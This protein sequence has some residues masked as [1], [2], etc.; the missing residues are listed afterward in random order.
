MQEMQVLPMG[1]EDPLEGDMAAYSSI[2]AWENPWTESMGLQ[3][4]QTCLTTKQ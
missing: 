2:L 1:Q 4:N 3:K